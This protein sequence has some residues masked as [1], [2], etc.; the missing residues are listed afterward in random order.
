MS[1]KVWSYRLRKRT[2]EV[3]SQFVSIEKEHEVAEYSDGIVPSKRQRL[4][5]LKTEQF[6][7]Q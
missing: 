7:G 1:A 6:C 4:T 3:L 2:I 5:S